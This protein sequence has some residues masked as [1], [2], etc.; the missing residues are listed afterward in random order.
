M[1]GPICAWGNDHRMISSRASPLKLLDKNNLQD[2]HAKSS[3]CY[4]L[5]KV[6]NSLS[7]VLIQADVK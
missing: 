5:K 4:R 3:N 7:L 2:F 1:K 6:A